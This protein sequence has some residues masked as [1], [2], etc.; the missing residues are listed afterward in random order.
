MGQPSRVPAV[1]PGLLDGGRRRLY[2]LV[3]TPMERATRGAGIGVFFANGI[4]DHIM[5]LPALRALLQV[6]PPRVVLFAMPEFRH[7]LL[8]DL[9]VAGDVPIHLSMVDGR[10]RFDVAESFDEDLDLF[11]S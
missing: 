6:L 10:N 7:V 3:S 5:T 2:C 8:A 1:P 9:V 4:G 11:V